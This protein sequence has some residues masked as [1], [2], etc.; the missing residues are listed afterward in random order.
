MSARYPYTLAPEQQSQLSPG[1]RRDA[2]QPPTLLTTT[3][4]NA[5]NAAVGIAG[6]TPV[7]TSSLSSPFSAFQQS[8]YPASPA[9]TMRGSSPMV[10]RASASFNTAYNPQQWGPVRGGSASTSSPSP[11]V[12]GQRQ[13]GSSTRVAVLAARPV[14]PDGMSS[15]IM[16]TRRIPADDDLMC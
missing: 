10:H 9:G 16:W 8:P 2:I 1:R 3:L 11:R 5:H 15:E 14:G 6:Q 12:G 7:S 4:D 13:T